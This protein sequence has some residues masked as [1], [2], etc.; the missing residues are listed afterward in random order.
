MPVGIFRTHI[1]AEFRN[2]LPVDFSVY[3]IYLGIELFPF[4]AVVLLV[5]DEKHRAH[6]FK[7][8]AG[9]QGMGLHHV[10]V[11]VFG[12]LVIKIT[13]LHFIRSVP[14]SRRSRRIRLLGND[15]QHPDHGIAAIQ[16]GTRAIYHFDP[17]YQVKG[18]G[19]YVVGTTGPVHA[20]GAKAGEH[21]PPVNQHQQVARFDIQAAHSVFIA[22]GAGYVGLL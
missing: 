6:V 19:V 21:P 1:H 5:V 12:R 11:H 8:I 17:F 4:D 2:D 14:D 22:H 13:A 9:N 3:G 18:Y 15:V 10:P 16:G 7:N 20:P